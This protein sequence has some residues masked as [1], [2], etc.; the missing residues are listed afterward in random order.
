MHYVQAIVCLLCL[1]G[2]ESGLYNMGIRGNL[3]SES[4]IKFSMDA[5]VKL[6]C[7]I[8]AIDDLI[9]WLNPE[10]LNY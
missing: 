4:A 3:L 10:Y 9:L 2:I 8:D 7:V 1:W 6:L 5:I